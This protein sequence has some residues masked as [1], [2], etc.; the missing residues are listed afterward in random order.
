VV[1]AST[2][3]Y[4]DTTSSRDS[5]FYWVAGVDA[6]GRTS[7]RSAPAPFAWRVATQLPAPLGVQASAAGDTVKVTWLPGPDSAVMEYQV[8]RAANDTGPYTRLGARVRAPR[9]EQRDAGRPA[10]QLSWYRVTALDAAGRE[11]APSATALAEVPDLTPPAAPD[12]LAAR[13]DTGRLSLRWRRSSASD[14]RG[15]R[16]YRAGTA[17]GTFGLLSATPQRVAAFTDTVPVRADHPFYY[18]VTAVDS[19]FNESAPSAVVA[20]RPPDVT[21]PSAPRIARVR[22]LDG[23]LA[24]A[25]LPNP[26][27]DVV[28]YRLRFRIR[29]DAAWHELPVAAPAA[30][31]ADT[32]TGLAPGRTH[33]VTLIAVDDAG[34]RSAPAPNVAGTPVRRRPP[35]ALEVRRASYERSAGGIV[36][37]WGRPGAAV[38]GIVVLRRQSEAAWRPIAAL[39]PAAGRFVDRLAR[40][41]VRYE[42]RL[43]ARDAFGNAADSRPRRVAVPEAGR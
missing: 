18:R 30:V 7:A 8:W 5:A 29:G 20:V 6:F 33:D 14:L 3:F 37:E 19:A 22:P 24:V 36:I 11:S 2:T 27:P 43:Q 34:N 42:Y 9:L 4:T 21:P 40:A 31:L 26:E 39:P 17:D 41:G 12:S 32:I 10:R 38:A 25:W 28:A 15:Y 1:E 13:S 35:D 23:A 16:V